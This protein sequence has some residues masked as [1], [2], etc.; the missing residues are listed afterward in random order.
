MKMCTASL[1]LLC[2]TLAVVSASA[3][4]IVYDNGPLNGTV[5]AWTINS[6]Y[7]VSDSF[8]LNFSGTINGVWTGGWLLPGDY[9]TSLDWSVTSS[10]NGGTVY[11]SGTATNLENQFI[12]TN[13]YG[14]DCYHITW[15]FN[16]FDLNAG[17]TY[18][19]NLQNA[20]TEGGNPAYWDE[21]SGPSSASESAV[22][23]IPSESFQ[24][25]GTPSSGSTPEPGTIAL[26]GAGVLGLAGIFRRRL[27]L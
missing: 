7:V 21:N 11:G 16:S 3:Q 22:G 12:S 2:L 9:M 6:G 24:I 20:V 23:T 18:W 13:Q 19:L 17:T 1:M 15:Y 26:F 25:I 8:S 10:E 14:Y 5:D 4:Q 27:K